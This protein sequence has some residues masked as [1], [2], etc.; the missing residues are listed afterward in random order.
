[1][2]YTFSDDE[3]RLIM[4]YYNTYSTRLSPIAKINVSNLLSTIMTNRILSTIEQ[5]DIIFSLLNVVIERRTID[6]KSQTRIKDAVAVEQTD[7]IDRELNQ[8]FG[9][10]EQM[11]LFR[12][13][14]EYE[15]CH[16]YNLERN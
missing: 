8:I 11:R 7:E 16:E 10:I 4:Y 13:H 9:I 5:V 3:W 2:V 15:S 14:L 6:E 12:H 1:M